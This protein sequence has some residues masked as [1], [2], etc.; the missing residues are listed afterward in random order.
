MPRLNGPETARLMRAQIPGL[1]IIFYTV[2][3]EYLGSYA[4]ME[5]MQVE[6]SEDLSELKSRVAQVLACCSHRKEKEVCE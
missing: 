1:P 3:C 6:K 4:G 5:E 2:R